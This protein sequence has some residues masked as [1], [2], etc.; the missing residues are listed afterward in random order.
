VW[1]HGNDDTGGAAAA[2]ER[3]VAGLR[4]TAVASLLQLVGAPD[5][6]AL[7]SAYELG[8]TAA[9]TLS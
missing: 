1:V 3:I 8:A 7:D 4:W 9:A 6:A 5:R 2:I